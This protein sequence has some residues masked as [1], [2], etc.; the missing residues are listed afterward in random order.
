LESI[1]ATKSG[2]ATAKKKRPGRHAS[3]IKRTRRNARRTAINRS[4]VSRI[5][6][7]LTRVE[8]AVKAGNRDEAVTAFKAAQPELH[9]G[10]AK[11]ALNRNTVARRLSRLNAR[12][13]AM[14]AA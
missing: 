11:G 3:A 12:I 8:A 7:A 9:R 14:A 13:K 5:K 10:A 4:R 6:T 1:M 2:T